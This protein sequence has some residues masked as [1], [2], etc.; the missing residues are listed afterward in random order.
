[1]MFAD[2]SGTQNE[3]GQPNALYAIVTSHEI[4]EDVIPRIML[5][6]QA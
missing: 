3:S 2:G 5:A 6:Q 4:L 1:M